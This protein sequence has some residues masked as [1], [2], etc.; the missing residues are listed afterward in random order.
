MIKEGIKMAV[1][2]G[3]GLYNDMSTFMFDIND[4]CIELFADVDML[5]RANWSATLLTNNNGLI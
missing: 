2:E 1:K 5:S 4:I 3:S